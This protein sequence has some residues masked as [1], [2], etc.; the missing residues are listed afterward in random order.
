VVERRG[1]LAVYLSPPN[2]A[3][4]AFDRQRRLGRSL[5]YP[6]NREANEASARVDG[7]KEAT[8]GLHGEWGLVVVEVAGNTG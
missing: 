5:E 8:V 7:G 2:C 6:E 3:R 4:Q 1:E